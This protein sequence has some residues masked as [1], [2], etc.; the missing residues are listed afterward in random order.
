MS[1]QKLI[2]LYLDAKIELDKIV[3]W[4]RA[5]KLTL[6]IYKTKYILFRDKSQ[7]VDFSGLNVSIKNEEIERIG[8]DIKNF[9]FQ[10]CLSPPWWTLNL[11]ISY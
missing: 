10:I 3:D 7:Y 9:F 1:S 5:D 6:Q 4:F 8:E 11:A 2:E